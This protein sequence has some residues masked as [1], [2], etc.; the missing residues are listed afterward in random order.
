MS[1]YTF[2]EPIESIYK[3]YYISPELPGFAVSKTG[4]VINVATAKRCDYKSY[5]GVE[6]V[7]IYTRTKK[8]IITGGHTRAWVLATVFVPKSKEL[9]ESGSILQVTFKDKDKTNCS[10]S[11]LKWG[12]RGDILRDNSSLDI[13]RLNQ[14]YDKPEFNES[15]TGLYPYAK[16]YPKMPGYY[17][18]PYSVHPVVCSKTG[19]AFNLHTKEKLPTRMTAFGYVDIGLRLPSLNGKARFK[20]VKLHR[21][22]ADLFCPKPESKET[23]F[24]NH[25][26]GNKTNNHA[27]NLEW[28]TARE[29]IQHAVNSGLIKARWITSRNVLTNEIKRYPSTR[30]VHLETGVA[31]TVL[32]KRLNNRQAAITTYNWLVFQYEDQGPE[33]P[34]IPKEHI[35][36]NRWNWDYKSVN[37]RQYCWVYVTNIKTGYKLRLPSQGMAARIAGVNPSTLSFHFRSYGPDVE[38]SGY[39]F[40][41]SQEESF[42]YSSTASKWTREYITNEDIAKLREGMDARQLS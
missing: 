33:W 38:L 34:E 16:E 35:V 24:V 2:Q 12:V 26:D 1:T 32:L 15:N 13:Q 18:V 42:T 3:G 11:N 28:V 36:Q 6:K 30:A 29:N 8:G 39:L 9:I 22:V 31:E 25:K 10:I 7:C 4:E 41:R 23:L 40:E 21:V 20:N 19:D 5:S 14:L 17:W 37:G 27:S